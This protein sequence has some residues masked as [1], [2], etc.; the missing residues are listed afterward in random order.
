M[1]GKRKI[2]SKGYIQIYKPDHSGADH[3]GY[4]REHRLVVEKKI[5]R[6]LKPKEVVHHIDGNKQNN[7][8]EN[9]MLFSNHQKHMKF[10]TKIIQF[11]YTGPVLKQI[12]ERWKK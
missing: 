8:I 7:K 4:V 10:H 9:L 5:G 3:K 2:D 1:E 6:Y 11:G 12:K